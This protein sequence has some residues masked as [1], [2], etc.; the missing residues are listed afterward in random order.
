MKTIIS[1][2]LM[3]GVI[4]IISNQQS[5]GQ[6]FQTRSEIIK[7][8]GPDYESD[9]SSNGTKYIVYKTELT[10][11]ESGTYTRHWVMYFTT[12][13][14]GTEYDGIEFCHFW[15]IFEPATETIPNMDYFNKIMTVVDFLKWKD[16]ESGI[17]YKIDVEDEIS[18]ITSWYDFEDM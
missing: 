5:F 8:H 4:L 2:F 14:D 6:L 13:D 10:T 15:Q 9:T 17:L 11:E 3:L 12:L 18:I 7:E 16:D 1:T